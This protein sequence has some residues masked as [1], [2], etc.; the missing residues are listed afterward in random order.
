MLERRDPRLP[1]FFTTTTSGDYIGGTPGSGNSYSTRS[2]TSLAT[3]DPQFPAQIISYSEVA[4]F[5]AE[6]AARGMDVGGTPEE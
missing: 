5:L 1:L 2:H 3:R 6:A 4:F